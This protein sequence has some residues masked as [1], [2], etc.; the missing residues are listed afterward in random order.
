M[1]FLL[2]FFCQEN[3]TQTTIYGKLLIYQGNLKHWNHNRW[4]LLFF[5]SRKPKTLWNHNMY[6]CIYIY[7]YIYTFLFFL[8]RKPE[9]TIT[10]NCVLFFYWGNQK[11]TL[12]PQEMENLIKTPP[13]VCI[14]L[15]AEQVAQIRT[16]KD[17]PASG[18]KRL[19][20][21]L[22]LWWLI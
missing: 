18:G 22:S 6:V 12:K 16:D 17:V 5:W 9:T 15:S 2:I 19:S 20:F 3:L 8:S 10:G 14:P 13:K 7:I 11:Q 21:Y 4:K 1:D